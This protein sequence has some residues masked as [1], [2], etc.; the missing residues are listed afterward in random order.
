MPIWYWAPW[1]T[2]HGVRYHGYEL[3]YHP[4]GPH[5]PGGRGLHV[6]TLPEAFAVAAVCLVLFLIFNYAVVATT[7]PTPPSPAGCSARWKTRCARRKKY[8][9][10]PARCPR[11]CAPDCPRR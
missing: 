9:A 10:A 11:T 8:S 2:V 5:G 1:Q 6:N 3:G 4:N 7:R